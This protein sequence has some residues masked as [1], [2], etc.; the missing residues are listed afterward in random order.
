MTDVT[1]ESPPQETAHDADMRK[2]AQGLQPEWEHTA[3]H[4]AYGPLTFRAKLPTAL[5][6]AQQ[7]VEMDN[8]LTNLDGD[9]R[10]GTMILV[11]AIAGLKTLVECPVVREER[12]EDPES[13]RTVISKVHYNPEAET[14]EVFLVEVWTAFSLW[15]ASF[16]AR[17]DDLGESSGETTGNGSN[18]PSTSPIA[19]PS[20]TPDSPPGPRPTT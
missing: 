17:S 18:E 19:S 1:T 15:R 7:S 16:M 10:Q 6:L 13:G 3:N 11:A 12:E 14:S 8:L 2:I 9:A 4:P 5:Q 20:T